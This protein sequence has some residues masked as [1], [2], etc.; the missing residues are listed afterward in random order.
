M[1]KEI[2]MDEEFLKK[3]C[4]VVTKEHCDEIGLW[5]DLRDT[6]E[7]LPNAMGVAAN[8]IGIDAR[9]CLILVRDNNGKVIEEI[10]LLNPVYLK[11][12]NTFK[13][14]S[15]GCLS[16]PNKYVNTWRYWNVTISDDINGE[17]EYNG[18]MAVVVQHEIDHMDGKTMFDHRTET[19]FRKEE[20]IGRN[21]P[22]RCGSGKK[23][24]KCCGK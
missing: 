12:D 5:G 23:Y 3:P 19:Y 10:K 18:F 6:C 22:C 24:K 16:F 15:E 11:Q 21:D 2:V 1:I 17:K 9:A 8:Q 14:E 4:S 7:N 13:F 20:K